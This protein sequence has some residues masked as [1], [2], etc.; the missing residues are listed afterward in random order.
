MS[1]AERIIRLIKENTRAHIEDAY[2]NLSRAAQWFTKGRSKNPYLFWTYAARH[3]SNVLNFMPLSKSNNKTKYELFFE[4]PPDFSRLKVFGCLAYT[5]VATALRKTMDNAGIES[6]YFG[7]DP[8]VLGTWKVLKIN[9]SKFVDSMTIVFNEN[10]EKQELKPYDRSNDVVYSNRLDDYWDENGEL[11]T[12]R[13]YGHNITDWETSS[14]PSSLLELSYLSRAMLYNQL[15]LPFHGFD[16]CEVP[17]L[18]EYTLRSS[19]PAIN[20]A[21]IAEHHNKNHTY[22][23]SDMHYYHAYAVHNDTSLPRNA[24]KAVLIPE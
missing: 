12:A 15:L 23:T 21:D 10:L 17:P 1:V 11:I 8:I 2:V 14:S 20:H 22:G 13:P 9:T 7:F 5:H 3:E 18:Y 16:Y 4:T 19:S 6:V 24:K